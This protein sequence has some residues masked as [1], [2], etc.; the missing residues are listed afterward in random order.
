[1]RP[2]NI[3]LVEALCLKL[4]AETYKVAQLLNILTEESLRIV[5]FSK[6]QSFSLGL[7]N[8]AT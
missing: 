2:K 7:G 4:A 3:A 8:M 6:M 1:M 5:G